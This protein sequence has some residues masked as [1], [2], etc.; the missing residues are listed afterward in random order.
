MQQLLI[1]FAIQTEITIESMTDIFNRSFAIYPRL[2][3]G[4]QITNRKGE[5]GAARF[6]KST[7]GTSAVI[8]ATAKNLSSKY[9]ASEYQSSVLV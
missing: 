5:E 8:S 3:F 6:C 1:G 7:L 2:L 9:R 4:D